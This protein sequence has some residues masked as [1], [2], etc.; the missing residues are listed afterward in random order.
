MKVFKINGNIFDTKQKAKEYL[1]ILKKEI[2]QNDI[3]VFKLQEEF[4][5]V[6]SSLS[7][8]GF[9][10]KVELLHNK[11]NLYS[12]KLN[13]LKTKLTAKYHRYYYPLDKIN[14][15]R[16]TELIDTIETYEIEECELQ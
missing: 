3:Q 10:Y 7:K 9:D 13:L 14:Y 1:L 5:S 4:T 16:N 15:L 6:L 8:V 11:G 12:V 2:E